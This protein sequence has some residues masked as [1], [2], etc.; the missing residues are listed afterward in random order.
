M[1]AAAREKFHRTKEAR[2]RV[3]LRDS[4]LEMGRSTPKTSPQAAKSVAHDVRYV[5]Q[6]MLIHS[7]NK[8]AM[9]KAL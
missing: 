8:Q 6:D 2:L 1:A 5:D 7:V 3:Q 9:D 4:I